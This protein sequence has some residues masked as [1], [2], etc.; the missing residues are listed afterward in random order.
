MERIKTRIAALTADREKLTKK[1]FTGIVWLIMGL[2]AGNFRIGGTNASLSAALIAALPLPQSC[3]VAAGSGIAA[4]INDAT[5]FNG[6]TLMSCGLALAARFITHNR[7]PRWMA[8]SLTAASFASVFLIDYIKEPSGLAVFGALIAA[9]LTL[10][11]YQALRPLGGI[12]Q[13]G[14]AALTT[15][16]A[17]LAVF[18]PVFIA[19]ASL[20]SLVGLETGVISVGRILAILAFLLLTRETGPLLTAAAG[21]LGGLVFACADKEMAVLAAALAVGGYAYTAAKGVR[22][23]LFLR[24]ISFTAFASLTVFCLSTDISALISV[25]E[26]IIAGLIALGVPLSLTSRLDILRQEISEPASL[27]QSDLLYRQ[28]LAFEEVGRDFFE[29]TTRLDRITERLRRPEDAVNAVC[30]SCREKNTCWNVNY[31]ES[32]RALGE[33]SQRSKEGKPLTGGAAAEYFKACPKKQSLYNAI[34]DC[35]KTKPQSENNLLA[36]KAVYNQFSLISRLLLADSQSENGIWEN[37]PLRQRLYTLCESEGLS[38]VSVS[39]LTGE[40]GRSEIKLLCRN[41][42]DKELRALIRSESEAYTRTKIAPP[43]VTRQAGGYSITA[44]SLPRLYLSGYSAQRSAAED[45]CGD[46]TWLNVTD[47]QGSFVLSD[48]M[49]TGVSAA[50]D[51]SMTMGIYMKLSEAGVEPEL[52]LK[53]AAGAMMVRTDTES[54]ATFDALLV[55]RYT[56]QA[57]FIKAGA[58]P[59]YILRGE[60]IIKIEGDSMPVGIIGEA[61][62]FT[63]KIKLVPG[64]LVLIASDGAGEESLL[65]SRLQKRGEQS[66]KTFCEAL[67]EECAARSGQGKT[68]LPGEKFAPKDDITIMAVEVM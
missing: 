58:T 42:P 34:S 44:A 24:H 43:S 4:L 66:L 19:G 16:Q 6:I 52:A 8:L 18:L 37:E 41:N 30:G 45:C 51:A 68:S 63:K 36:K 26:I 20:Q 62:C 60:N 10:G 39:A 38:P 50:L 55:D 9:A 40:S 3:L 13:N 61:E 21:A 17:K 57:R 12:V 15:P 35:V 29:A 5:R 49:G 32:E 11:A 47:T 56:A 46:V 48:G 65:C 31:E 53:S 27:A 22:T 28:S 25:Y 14:K 67:A 2:L 23:G 7:Q 33:L 1:I 64:D 54:M 59:S